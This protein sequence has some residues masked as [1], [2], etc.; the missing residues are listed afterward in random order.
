MLR[1][2]FSLNEV[3]IVEWS[4][5]GIVADDQLLTRKGVLG[6]NPKAEMGRKS[7]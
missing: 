6:Q 7:Q 2:L 4:F 3:K 5:L 1:S